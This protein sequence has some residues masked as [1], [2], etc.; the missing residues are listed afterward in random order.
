MK[1]FNIVRC[2]RSE[3]MGGVCFYLKQSINHKTSLSYCNSICEVLIVKLSEPDV[4]LALI[5][6]PPNATAATFN[7]IIQRTEDTIRAL[8]SPLPEVM[9]LGD[10]NF[11]GVLWDS[12]ISEQ[13]VHLSRLVRLRDFLYLDQMIKDPTLES[14]TL[15]LLF[16]NESIM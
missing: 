4:V 13:N 14:N 15:D 11:P 10:F 3:R 7:D 9:M 6:K 16:C 2:D 8:E 12:T 1:G 5:Y